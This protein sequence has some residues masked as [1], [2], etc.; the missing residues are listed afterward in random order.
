MS[1]KDVDLN[2]PFG[3]Y[4]Y[5]AIYITAHLHYCCQRAEILITCKFSVNNLRTFL[6]CSF[7]FLIIKNMINGHRS[8]YRWDV[9]D[10]FG[11]SACL[12]SFGALKSAAGSPA[13]SHHSLFCS[14]TVHLPAGGSVLLMNPCSTIPEVLTSEH[15]PSSE[16]PAGSSFFLPPLL[17]PPGL[18][19]GLTPSCQHL[20]AANHHEVDPGLPACV[21]T[22]CCQLYTPIFMHSSQ[23]MV[24][25][26]MRTFFTIASYIKMN[27]SSLVALTI[28]TDGAH[29]CL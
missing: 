27:D 20:G 25:S 29:C 15:Y 6:Q 1:C 10:C 19:V 21:L 22:V 3:L 23:G 2:I 4:E 17:A 7:N 14:A 8:F 13:C 24:S 12:T 28:M 5:T 18:P 11:I 9:T 26:I 16:A